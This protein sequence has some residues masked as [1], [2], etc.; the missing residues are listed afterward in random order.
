L[1]PFAKVRPFGHGEFIAAS[2]EH[3]SGEAEIA[4]LG[5]GT[6]LLLGQARFFDR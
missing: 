4:M 6:P 1:H 3:R 5:G 2:D